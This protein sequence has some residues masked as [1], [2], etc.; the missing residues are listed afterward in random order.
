MT[1]SATVNIY[2]IKGGI[3]IEE[4]YFDG[5]KESPVICTNAKEA[6][7]EIA[8]IIEETD[9]NVRYTLTEK[10]EK[11]ATLMKQG[12]SFEEAEKKIGE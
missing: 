7:N 9:P 3:L 10:G 11:L 6:Y 5:S 4:V 8:R 12:M 1:P 2:H